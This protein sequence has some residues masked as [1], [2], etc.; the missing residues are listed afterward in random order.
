[1]NKILLEKMYY[2]YSS[3]LDLAQLFKVSV[4]AMT[5]RLDILNLL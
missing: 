4:S 5:V 2:G 3:I 1:M